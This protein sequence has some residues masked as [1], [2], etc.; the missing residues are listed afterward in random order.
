MSTVK[1]KAVYI[2]TKWADHEMKGVTHWFA[3]GRMCADKP[4]WRRTVARKA[5]VLGDVRSC[6]RWLPLDIHADYKVMP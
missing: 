5:C 1:M 3:G 6:E 4:D 2:A